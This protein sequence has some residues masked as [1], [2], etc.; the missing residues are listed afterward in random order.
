[1][2]HN[3]KQADHIAGKPKIAIVADVRD[4]A[5]HNIAAQIHKHLSARYDI[6]ILY[7][8]DYNN[9]M[10]VLFPDLFCRGFKL[11]HFLWRS[12][13]LEIYI[14]LKSLEGQK[15]QEYIRC[16]ADTPTTFSIYDHCFLSQQEILERTVLFN[17]L[18]NGYTVSSRRLCKTYTDIDSYRGPD[19]VIEDGV[20][21]EIFYPEN[22]ER[23]SEENRD[24]VVGWV[25][26]SKWW[27]Y[28]GVDHK[29][30]HTLIKPAIEA[31]KKEGIAIVGNF[32]DRNER[33]IPFSEMVDYYR[34]IDVYVCA[35]D[36]EGTPNPV[37]EAMACGVP[38]ISTDVG[39][40]PDVF[41]PLQSEFIL[42]ERTKDALKESLRRVAASPEL[43]MA[44][45]RENLTQIKEWTRE[46][47]SRKWDVF[48]KKHLDSAAGAEKAP[49]EGQ[50]IASARARKMAAF[51]LP[52]S[53]V[54][55]G[56]LIR[57]WRFLKSGLLARYH[58]M[59]YR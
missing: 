47:E 10:S 38:V 33:F 9:D 45:S 16:F 19:M 6:E 13:L 56:I 18:A 42:K 30:L 55:T 54:K 43:R 15:A 5:F 46:K 4:W 31:L 27:S 21:A 58:G 28:D 24:I 8:G 11:V 53:S 2:K 36:I 51:S 52:D 22:T 12:T 39:I 25:G 44:L 26:N 7:I 14:Y 34:A 57:G 50:D 20:N 23:L 1:M 40:V 17:N 59:R 49:E 41:G 29:G 32:A 3:E 35:S 37:L 48:F